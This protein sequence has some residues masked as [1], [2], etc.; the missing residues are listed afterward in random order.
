[1][2]IPRRRAGRV[3]PVWWWVLIWA[4]LLVCAAAYIGTCLWGLW[5]QSKEFGREVA[6]AQ[7]RLE[8]VQGQLDL[9][10]DK[11]TAPEQLAVFG[12]PRTVRRERHAIRA[13]L[14]RERRERRARSLPAWA[15]H[16][17]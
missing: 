1:M 6:I 8:Q 17:D 5:G 2:A 3:A 10:G 9:L 4:L 15:R 13:S 12:D 7:R 11:I 14:R 16:V